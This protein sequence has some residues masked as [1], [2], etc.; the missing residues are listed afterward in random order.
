MGATSGSMMR[1]AKPLAKAHTAKTRNSGDMQRPTLRP[2][3]T[4]GAMHAPVSSRVAARLS[5]AGDATCAP[6]TSRV[7]G[8]VSMSVA[9]RTTRPAPAASPEDFELQHA[10][11]TLM[12]L[13]VKTGDP[14]RLLHALEA[15]YGAEPPF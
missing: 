7:P 5:S 12:A 9:A 8:S 2:R 10:T 15:R 3:A 11:L 4:R 14:A 1:S 6:Y 13:V